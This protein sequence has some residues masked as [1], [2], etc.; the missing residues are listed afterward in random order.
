MGAN[1]N[2]L[3]NYHFSIADWASGT[4]IKVRNDRCS[5]TDCAVVTDRDVRGMHFIDVDKLADP[6]SLS[7]VCA[8]HAMQKRSYAETSRRK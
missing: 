7:D 5:E 4:R 3:F 1:E 2:V 8:A 6:Y